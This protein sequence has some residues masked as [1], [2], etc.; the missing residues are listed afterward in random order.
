MSHPVPGTSWLAVMLASA[1]GFGL[2]LAPTEHTDCIRTFVRDG[3]YPALRGMDVAYQYALTIPENLDE[4]HSDGDRQALL[5]SERDELEQRCRELQS[6]NARMAAELAQ[7]RN[8]HPSPFLAEPG[9]PLFVPELIAANIIGAEEVQHATQRVS[10]RRVLDAGSGKDIIPSDFVVTAASDNSGSEPHLIDQGNDSGV[11]VD[12]PV[13]AGRCVVGKVGQVGRWTSTVVPV[14]DAAFRGRAQL[15]RT[16]LQGLVL[17]AEGVLA[18]D[19]KGSCRLMHIPATEPVAVGDEVYTNHRLVDLPLP[20]YYGRVVTARLV[21]GAPHWEIT[22]EPAAT[23]ETSRVVHVLRSV[24]NT[25][26][27]DPTAPIPEG[28]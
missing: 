14:T 9:T 15:V 8:G 17:G 11:R 27:I 24:L 10:Y 23:I 1:G 19:G 25:A 4:T 21:E 12:Q 3:A 22:V 26:R 6:I 18:G 16:A 5:R 7:A 20:M 13:F 28:L 2:L